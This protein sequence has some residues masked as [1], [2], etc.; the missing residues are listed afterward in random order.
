VGDNWWDTINSQLK[1]WSGTNWTVIGP[2]FTSVSGTS[3]A[4][5]ETI[6]DNAGNPHIVVK[7]YV[8]NTVIAILSNGPVFTPQTA[9]AGFDTIKPGFNLVGTSTVTG[10]QFTGTASVATNAL[11]LGGIAANSYVTSSQLSSNLTVSSLSISSITKTGTDGSGDIG[12]SSNKFANVYAGNFIGIPSAPSLTKT[13]TDGVGDIGQLNNK[14]NNIYAN[15][16]VGNITSSNP[17]SVPSLTKTGTDGSGDIGQANNRFNNI[18]ANNFVGNI[19]SSNPASVPSLT[20]TGVDGVGNI[21]QSDNRFGNVY[22]TYFSGTA[23]TANYADLAERFAADQPYAPGTV[24]ALGGVK[25]ITAVVEDLSDQ[26]FGVISTRAGFLMNGAA[27]DDQSHPAVAVNGR[28]PVRVVGAVKKG[29]RLVS[30]GN[31]LARAAGKNEATAFNVIGRSLEDKEGSNESVIEAI[32]KL[33][34]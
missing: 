22:A 19:A 24:V 29:D 6:T 25:E 23:I 20:K 5:V 9:V 7:F 21:G 12:Q 26:V 17:A 8:A 2:A 32:V 1:V 28:V 33:N 15:N 13:G 10:A 18:Y 14:F 3:G 16:F 34:S 4:L 27:G 31:G 11:S 30:A